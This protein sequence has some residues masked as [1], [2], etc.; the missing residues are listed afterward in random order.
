MYKTQLRKRPTYEEIIGYLE[1]KQPEVKYPNRLA[2]QISNTPQMS[3][4]L[5]ESSLD[6]HLQQENILKQQLLLL[7]LQKAGISTREAKAKSSQTVGSQAGAATAQTEYYDLDSDAENIGDTMNKEEE[8]QEERREQT[9]S[10]A[11]RHLSEEATPKD[12]AHEMAEE[13]TGEKRAASQE[14]RPGREKKTSKGTHNF[15]QPGRSR[16]PLRADPPKDTGDLRLRYKQKSAPPPTDTLPPVP[17][18][19]ASS[20]AYPTLNKEHSKEKVGHIKRKEQSAPPPSTSTDDEGATSS[21]VYGIS[22]SKVGIQLLREI[23]ENAYNKGKLSQNDDGRY[24]RA[25]NSFNHGVKTKDEGLKKQGL[26]QLR[27]LYRKLF[28]KKPVF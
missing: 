19:K 28:Y 1:N 25:L 23:L 4:F 18:P 7:E 26:E 21:N 5:G 27:V 16:S 14:A 8:K 3:Q 2:T 9:A 22:P 12:A 24:Q 17:P 11:S 20:S 6:M 15:H 13:N 10:A